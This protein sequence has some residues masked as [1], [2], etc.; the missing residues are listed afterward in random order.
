MTLNQY[1]AA[2]LHHYTTLA[3]TP[4]HPRAPDRQLASQLFFE[5]VSIETVRAAF[6]LVTARRHARASRESPLPPIRSLHYFLPVI[7]EFHASPLDSSY[8]RLLDEHLHH[9]S[10]TSAPTPFT[11]HNGAETW[12]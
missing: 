4:A 7:R 1:R 11:T 2:V 12:R 10:E 5:G 8:L 9:D 3:D 6:L